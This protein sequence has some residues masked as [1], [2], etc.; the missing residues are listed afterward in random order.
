MKWFCLA[1]KLVTRGSHFDPVRLLY[2]ILA[3]AASM[4][5]TTAILPRRSV[6][7]IESG[8]VNN[9]MIT[10]RTSSYGRSFTPF[11]L[12]RDEFCS[13]LFETQSSHLFLQPR[14][15]PW[16]PSLQFAGAFSTR[17]NAYFHGLSILPANLHRI[18]TTVKRPSPQSYVVIA[19]DAMI[20]HAKWL[21]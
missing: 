20:S 7:M 4:S 17:N 15:S 9:A 5:F 21:V 14:T 12:A 11:S 18:S 8:F 10:L 3:L 19:Y 13:C 6:D 16:M 1:N 2:D